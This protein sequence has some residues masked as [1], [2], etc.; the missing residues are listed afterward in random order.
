VEARSLNPPGWNWH[1]ILLC[2]MLYPL[3]PTL[4]CHCRHQ[5]FRQ[6]ASTTQGGL[7]R[8]RVS[9]PPCSVV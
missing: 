6:T 5:L 4:C 1:A 3:Q 7:P 2:S 8:P 9:T